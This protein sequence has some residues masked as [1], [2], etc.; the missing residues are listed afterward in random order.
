MYLLS[1]AGAVARIVSTGR[2][3]ELWLITYGKVGLVALLAL[4][5]GWIL[6]QRLALGIL[7]WPLAL[8]SG[9]GLLS[10][11]IGLLSWL[12]CFTPVAM[13]TLAALTAAMVAI[14]RLRGSPARSIGP[15]ARDLWRN[16][17]IRLGT[18]VLSIY[19]LFLSLLTLFPAP[20]FD[21]TTYH[22]PLARDLLQGQGFSYD[23]YVRYS[24]FPQANE[25]LF[26]AV[27]MS[28]LD[29]SAA[30]GIQ[31]LM[32]A[33]TVSLVGGWFLA[34]GRSAGSAVGAALL[35]VASPVIVYPATS[36]YIDVGALAFLTAG[37][38]T[39]ALIL[40]KRLPESWATWGLVGL[41]LGEVAATKYT[42]GGYGLVV[43]VALLVARRTGVG[44]LPALGGASLGLVIAAL[45]WYAWTIHL[46]GDPVY[47]FA[48]GIF[49]NRPGLWTEAEIVD[50][51][52]SARGVEGSVLATI[53]RD[54]Q[55]LLGS[56]P[57][58]VAP[59]ISPLHPIIW[60]GLLGVLI[61]SVRRSA[62]F[63]AAWVGIILCHGVWLAASSDPRY[64]IPVFGMLAI[65]GGLALE[66][67]RRWLGSRRGWLAG[68]GPSWRLAWVAV[69][70]ASLLI[71][72]PSFLDIQRIF[73][74]QLPP[75]KSA[76][77]L[78]YL[79]A[80][81]P[82][83]SG[84]RYLNQRLGAA[85]VAYGVGCE[86]TRYF[87]QGTYIGDWYGRGSYGRVLGGGTTKLPPPEILASR[88]RELR[89]QYLL[90]PTAHFP[91]PSQLTRSGQF[92]LVSTDQET[93]V[94]LLSYP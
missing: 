41:L 60:I 91:D 21:A 5:L 66:P 13:L 70:L 83:L 85:Y 56:V 59:G 6:L 40:E 69:P 17:V 28:S 50:Q 88:L 82:C 1:L 25:A 47:P 18:L 93:F 12:H 75:T 45:P 29:A 3:T 73:G 37:F 7:L 67:T 48:T 27:M 22:L 92:R 34:T 4:G 44:L 78:N 81:H 2:V 30:A 71:L 9:F 72:W 86:E 43:L 58:D 23:P 57:G 35:V 90:L 62:A 65:A 19:L 64:L 20:G 77:V 8:I 51:T 76:D 11:L 42:G 79:Y 55:Y 46:T 61:P 84:L 16:P 31:L 24:F 10:L 53:E 15:T 87:A 80:R 74:I 49:G 26:A 32:L 68:P 14:L 39:G 54:L 52:I 94:L 89:V 36:A 33:A 63:V 38:V